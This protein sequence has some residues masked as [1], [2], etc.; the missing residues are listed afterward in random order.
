LSLLSPL[1]KPLSRPLAFYSFLGAH[2]LLIGLLPFYLP[3]FLWGRGFEL[4]EVVLLIAATGAGFVANL[5]PWQRVATKHSLV[6][7]LWLSFA[8]E[9][10]L[11]FALIH[12]PLL[13]QRGVPVVIGALLIGLLSGSYN[14]WFWTTQRSLF[15]ALTHAANTGRQYGN[16]QIFVTVFL[17]LGILIGGWLIDANSTAWILWLSVIVSAGML[18]WY[19]MALPTQ[20]L[21][22]HSNESVTLKQS[23][24][25][26]DQSRLLLA[27]RHGGGV[28]DIFRAH[29][30]ALKKYH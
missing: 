22:L 5:G 13:A 21:N 8:L 14:A 25:Y 3:V 29:F 19:H 2:S 12:W 24:S 11:V 6:R 20:A 15:L 7:L 16:F 10:L 4:A 9:C 30:L 26:R 1:A 28:S 17:K 27:W 18:C 23:F